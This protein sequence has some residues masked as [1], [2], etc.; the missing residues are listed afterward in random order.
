MNCARIYNEAMGQ[1]HSHILNNPSAF[2]HL[3]NVRER[4]HFFWQ[5]LELQDSLVLNG[6][7]LYAL[8]LEK[9]EH[10][11]ILVLPHNEPSQCE[12]LRGQ[13]A[14]RNKRM[15]GTGQEA[16]THACDRC[17]LV[18]QDSIGQQGAF[19]LCVS[20]LDVY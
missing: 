18:F 5:S 2:R 7:F 16:Y 11:T 15:E 4:P 13:L 19:S 12:R 20:Y 6:F 8:L 14:E 10:Q 3:L 17:F 9:E 1:R